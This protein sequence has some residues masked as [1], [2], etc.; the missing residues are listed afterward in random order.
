MKICLHLLWLIIRMR[1]LVVDDMPLM[2]HVLI[3]MLRQLDYKD[4]VEATDGL[5]ALT[6][7]K[8]QLIDLVI[9]DLHMPKMDGLTLLDA[10][11]KD[12]EHAQLPVLMVTCEDSSETVK[13]IINAK[14]S[15]FII[16]PFSMNVLSAQLT[17]LA[18]KV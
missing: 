5:Q 10:I 15:G 14:V 13:K 12:T 18:N 4:I 8:N 9:T 3:N 16:K 6:I 17:R 11:R 1:I 2:R 7:L